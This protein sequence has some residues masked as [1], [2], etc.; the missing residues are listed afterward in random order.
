MIEHLVTSIIE[1][2]LNIG[3]IKKDDVNVYRYGYTLFIEAFLNLMLTLIVSALLGKIKACILALIM[4]IPLRSFCGGYHAKKTWQC[5]IFSNLSILSV[6]IGAELFMQYNIPLLVYMITDI[7]LAIIII[8][9]SP[10]ESNNHTLN[11]VERKHF[12]KY[13]LVIISI[14]ILIGN[15]LL[16]MGYQEISNIILGV[17]ILQLL[18]LLVSKYK[19]RYALSV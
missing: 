17:H 14:E 13:A 9:C 1:Y 16:I 6:V 8:C 12:Q 4:F 18:A 7:V 11:D 3:T 2:Q 15:T 10:A 5:I 19:E